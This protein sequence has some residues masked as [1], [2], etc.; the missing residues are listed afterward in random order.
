MAR[1][2]TPILESRD[3]FDATVA[4]CVRL[5][6]AIDLLN[7]RE[8]R[9]KQRVID[10][11]NARRTPLEDKLK[12]QS[13]LAEKYADAHRAELLPSAE[14][15]SADIGPATIGY[16]NGNPK[17]KIIGKAWT[18][19]KVIAALKAQKLTAYIATKEDIAKAKILADR[20][21]SACVGVDVLTN[22]EGQIVALSVVGL[23]I[24]QDEVFYIEPKTDTTPTIKAEAA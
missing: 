17:T 3:E 22:S 23:V 2:K 13:A 15:K 20:K 11:F 18:E 21:P 12:A 16:R 4:D 8:A 14:R 6:Q 19:E 5:Q 1:I 9:A 24:A 7:A 10:A